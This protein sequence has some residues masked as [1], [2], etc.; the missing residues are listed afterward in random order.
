MYI[1]NI[2]FDKSEWSIYTTI[3]TLFIIII[4][5]LGIYEIDIPFLVLASL[6]AMMK[7]Q[8]VP[9]LIYTIFLCLLT[10]S[11]SIHFVQNTFFSVLA[12][13]IVH[14]IKY[15]NKLHKYTSNN[16]YGRNLVFISIIGWFITIVYLLYVE[17]FR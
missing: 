10:W 17:I 2:F 9:K 15:N 12:T 13:Y 6:I 7:G 16:F 4:M 14:Y 3:Q 8:L 11:T 5:K 1:K